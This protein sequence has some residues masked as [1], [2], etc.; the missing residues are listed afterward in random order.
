MYGYIS[1]IDKFVDDANQPLLVLSVQDGTAQ[2]RDAPRLLPHISL[3]GRNHWCQPIAFD[4]LGCREH[5][6]PHEGGLVSSWLS[7]LQRLPAAHTG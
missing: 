5:S 2:V 3:R 4:S 6:S 1:G 7:G